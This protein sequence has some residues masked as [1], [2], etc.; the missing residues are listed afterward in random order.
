MQ[1]LGHSQNSIELLWFLK[2]NILKSA[3]TAAT[4][5]WKGCNEE[6]KILFAVWTESIRIIM[7]EISGK[8]VA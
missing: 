3:E 7:F 2:K 6:S 1:W 4:C 8:A 5:I